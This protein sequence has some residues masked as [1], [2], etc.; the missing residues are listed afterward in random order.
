M[1]ELFETVLILSLLGFCITLVLLILRPITAK[2]FPAKWQYYVW[3]AVLLIMIIPLYKLIPQT[4]VQNFNFA[5]QRETVQREN[6]AAD[7]KISGEDTQTVIIE[8]T[9]IEYREINLNANKKI[10]LL[11]L[12]AY[13]WALGCG[14]F[15]TVI[16]TNYII[17]TIRRRKKSVSL[18]DSA[19]LEEVKKE[20][21][22]K[23]HIKLRMSPDINSPLLVGVFFPV[24]Y[25][26]CREIPNEN[27]K[28]VFL[29]EL[30]HY[31]RKDLII[32]WLS[33][34]VNAVHWFNPLSYLLLA[35]I[36]ESCEV[37]CDMAVTK[38]MSDAQQKLYMKTILDLVE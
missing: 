29:H 14:I 9:P 24:V 37:S 36:G 23:R 34:F 25:I 19:I 35:N 16:I 26:P 2:K 20:L 17:F 22:I 18:K 5:L 28:M 11:D 12:I 38:N 4:E 21:N 33:I 31:K 13:I 8:Q 6:S 32:K 10:R 1:Y 15:L 7:E 30:T 3:V 27:M